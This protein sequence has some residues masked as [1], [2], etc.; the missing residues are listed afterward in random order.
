MQSYSI[1]RQLLDKMPEGPISVKVPRKFPEG[2]S[3]SRYEAPRGECVHYLKSNGTD[4]P[5]R[6]KAR[7]PTMAN[8]QAVACMLKNN[9]LADVPITIAAID[10]CFSCTDRMARVRDLSSGID[11]M[12][13]WES[14]RARGIEFYKQRGIDFTRLNALMLKDGR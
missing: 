11:E 14:L 13:D 8:V 10:P 7:A 1:I 6:F 12:M 2:E 3:F 9:N 4:K 5:E